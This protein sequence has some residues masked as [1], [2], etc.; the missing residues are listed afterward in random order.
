MI[1]RLYFLLVILMFFGSCVLPSK[2]QKV[3]EEKYSL[4]RENNSLKYLKEQNKKDKAEIKLLKD[5]IDKT[6]QLMYELNTKLTASKE[7][8]NKCQHDYDK[9]LMEN[10]KLLERAF[11][12]Q[13]NL[14]EELAQKQK[15]L[16]EKER[17]LRK[18]ESDLNNQKLKQQLLNSDLELREHKIDSLRTLIQM[19][20]DK[21]T[22]IKKK[23][24]NVLSGYS[25]DDIMVEK[26]KD[27]RLYIS[28]SQNL[29]FAKGSNKLDSKGK[30]ALINVAKAL[31]TEP[32]IHI[33][34]EGHTD[35]DGSPKL[36][37]ELSTKRALAVTDV[38]IKNGLMPQQITAAGRGQYQPLVPNDTESNKSKNRRT[39]IIL[40]PNVNDIVN[41]LK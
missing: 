14:S 40:E 13:S 8:Y 30:S 37:W 23:I 16:A 27:G 1:N 18:L 38:L 31:K 10:N 28:L 41:F 34:V 2:Y 19:K 24:K 22:A 15:L 20:D 39:E 29:L 4:M 33:I 26:R 9:M 12:E 25:N 35:T 11:S 5:K 32:S 21:L 7:M 17:S 6:E 36:N 3:E